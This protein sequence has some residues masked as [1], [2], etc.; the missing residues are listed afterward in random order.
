MSR[1]VQGYVTGALVHDRHAGSALGIFVLAALAIGGAVFV[2]HSVET[3][4][5]TDNRPPLAQLRDTAIA[6]RDVLADLAPLGQCSL[7]LPIPHPPPEEGQPVINYDRWAQRA[8]QRATLIRQYDTAA[9]QYRRV[10]VRIDH[11][12]D[13][14]ALAGVARAAFTRVSEST[15]VTRHGREVWHKVYG[16]KCEK[17]DFRPDA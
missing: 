13:G 1:F 17:S 2:T 4:N 12:A 14:V 7:D 3:K 11:Q 16:W 5:A 9:D 15:V 10:E 6:R 8:I